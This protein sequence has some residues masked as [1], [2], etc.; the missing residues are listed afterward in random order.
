MTKTQRWLGLAPALWLTLLLLGASPARA[1]DWLWV[2]SK[3]F[4]VLSSAAE[5]RAVRKVQDLERVHEA[6]L[7]ALRVEE[8]LAR[9]PFTI[10]L[11]DDPDIIG[12]AVPHLRQKGM[13]GVFM[14]RDDGPVAF[15]VN[16]PGQESFSGSVLFHEYAHRVQAQYARGAYPVWFVEGFAEFFGSSR[17]LDNGVEVGAARPSNALVLN[18]RNWLPPE[19]LLKPSF[20]ATGQQDADDRHFAIFYAQSWLLTHY[21]L[22]DPARK[23]RFAEYF[24][25]IGAG[26]DPL[27]A[28]EPATGIALNRLNKLLRGYMEAVYASEYPVG[29][30]AE[31]RVT[32][33]TREEGES[34]LDA[35]ILRGV[36]EAA[37]G[38]VVLERLRQRVAKAGGERASER[39]RL[40]LAYAEIRYG[41][42]D[43]ALDLL[44][45]W[46]QRADAPFEANRLLGWAWQTAAATSSGTERTEAL[47]VARIKLM[48]AYK[49]RRN[50]APTLYQLARVLYGQG[51][52]ANLSNA[53]DTASLLDPQVSNY[54]YLAVAVHL[55]AGNRDKALPPLQSL[56]SNPHGGEGTE[57]ARAALAA[58]QS[59]QDTDTVLALLN[60]SKKATP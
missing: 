12:Q 47:D 1:A 11:S 40:A 59:N 42:V 34:E 23:E 10:V 57:R 22:K 46:G 2:E 37:Y 58:L 29:P 53:A 25:R 30:A 35:L 44:A 38:K 45:P 7:L 51:P 48:A 39:M 17:V 49:Q 21:V 14:A 6:M 8:K 24:R 43:R 3:H 13:A 32:R 36:P 50:D 28:F 31:V 5:G 33:L 41:D 19:Q 55:Q 54:A 18:E 56:A 15:A 9:P 16:Y 26:E 60:G 27:T 4:R 52:G 20:Q